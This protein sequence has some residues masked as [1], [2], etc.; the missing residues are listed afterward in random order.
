MFDWQFAEAQNR[1][2]E[3]VELALTE[4]PQR[5]THLGDAVVVLS[6][7]E[8]ERITGKRPGI[9]EQFMIGPSLEMLDLTRDKS[10]MHD[11]DL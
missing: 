3:V 9:V 10:V 7:A 5:V 6:E 2:N 1:F 8:Y 4:G 11:I